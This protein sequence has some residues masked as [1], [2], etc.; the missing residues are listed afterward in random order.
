MEAVRV[1]LVDDEVEFAEV[2]G[3][4][5]ESRGFATATASNGD[6]ALERFGD[7]D[8]D[9]VLLDLVMPGRDGLET[10]REI[11]SRKPL[12]EVIMLSGRGTEEAAIKGMKRGAFDFLTKPPDI[13]DLVEKVN[14]AHAKRAE[15]LARI[16]NALDAGQEEGGVVVEQV[17]PMEASETASAAGDEI[18]RQ[19]RLLVFGRESEFSEEMIEYALEMAERLSYEVFAMNA[20]GFSKEAL[21]SFPS[22]RERVCRDF[23]IASEENVVPFQEA[24]AKKGIP[25]SH[26]V[27]FAG[28][29]EAIQEIQQEVGQ[30]DF[31]V[32]EAV[33]G[34][35]DP[36]TGLNILVYSP[37]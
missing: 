15:H 17:A 1:L 26:R 36:D 23:R 30:V 27:T 35:I 34:L 6:E 31:V 32:S 13:G 18:P 33:D 8:F 14:D 16:R 24:A 4:R 10:L 22:A 21:R 5:L 11:K 9:V 20:A 25:F 7:E 29:D 28:P 3:R 12:T 37:T 19:G 2:L